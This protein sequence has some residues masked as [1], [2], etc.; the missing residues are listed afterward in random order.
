MVNSGS[1]RL[2]AF[3]EPQ[4]QEATQPAFQ[5]GSTDA[6]SVFSPQRPTA[7][8]QAGEGLSISIVSA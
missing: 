7:P 4:H 1:E 5:P 3:P 8:G 2:R 6:Q